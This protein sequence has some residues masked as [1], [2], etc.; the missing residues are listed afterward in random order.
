M[1]LAMQ[2][3]EVISMPWKKK[4][5]GV[6]GFWAS[7]EERKVLPWRWKKKSDACMQEAVRF[8][9]G[10]R[11]TSLCVETKKKKEHRKEGG[12]C[13]LCFERTR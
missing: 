12:K 13:C 7:E 9:G 3:E 10:A 6:R 1:L 11:K 2:K 8:F 4:K 5:E